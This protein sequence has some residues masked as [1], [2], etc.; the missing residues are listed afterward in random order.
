MKQRN[1]ILMGNIRSP[2]DLPDKLKRAM[3][4][5]PMPADMKFDIRFAKE[6]GILPPHDALYAD[7]MCWFKGNF[8][9]GNRGFVDWFE[10][11]YGPGTSDE[12]LHEFFTKGVAGIEARMRA[13]MA[14]ADLRSPM[15]KMMDSVALKAS[16]KFGINPRNAFKVFEDAP[17]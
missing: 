4:G 8:T 3:L 12:L 14:G 1:E 17:N 7:S 6:Q 2:L 11:N 5:V 10:F 13:A 15:Q 9:V 16:E